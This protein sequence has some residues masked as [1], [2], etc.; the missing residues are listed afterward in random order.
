MLISAGSFSVFLRRR[1]IVVLVGVFVFVASI[2]T[3]AAEAGAGAATTEN[4][5]ASV[6]SVA[7]TCECQPLGP[8]GAVDSHLGTYLWT[9]VSTEWSDQD[10]IQEFQQ[11][12]APIVTALPGFQRYTAAT[13]GNTTTVFFYDRL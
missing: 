12:F 6:S 13:T 8:P 1:W 2:G 11:G 5:A 9:I 7:A 4:A 10:V 3:A